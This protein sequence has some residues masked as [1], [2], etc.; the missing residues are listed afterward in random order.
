M[1]NFK[2]KKKKRK[3]Y[4]E[5]P[6]SFLVTITFHNTNE[7]P[8]KGKCAVSLPGAVSTGNTGVALRLPDLPS[9]VGTRGPHLGPFPAPEPLSTSPGGCHQLEWAP[10]NHLPAMPVLKDS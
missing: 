7:D 9:P 5:G 1:L 2:A 4:N 3:L 6:I 10:H 8:L